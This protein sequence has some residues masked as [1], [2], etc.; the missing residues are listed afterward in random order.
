MGGW[1]LKTP[2]SDYV[3]CARPLIYR[4]QIY[5]IDMKCFYFR[6]LKE[7]KNFDVEVDSELFRLFLLVFV[8]LPLFV[9]LFVFLCV[10]VFV[11]VFV[12]V[13]LFAVGLKET[14]R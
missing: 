3:I 1:S 8:F 7:N 9:F 14:C 4:Y 11:F 10:F 12:L 6:P 5:Y 13:I 2:K